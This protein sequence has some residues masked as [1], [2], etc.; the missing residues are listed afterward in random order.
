MLS[1][2]IV[3]P[4]MF[5]SEYAIA[6]KKTD[7]FSVPFRSLM[8]YSVFNVD[9]FIQNPS[10]TGTF[11][12]MGSPG[13]AFGSSGGF[14]TSESS[15]ASG[16]PKIE[17][18]YCMRPN[19]AMA[20]YGYSSKMSVLVNSGIKAESLKEGARKL[21]QELS[22]DWRS[23]KTAAD[24]KFI[25]NASR[26][27]LSKSLQETEK[28]NSLGKALVKNGV[29]LNEFEPYI[30]NTLE[31][32][33]RYPSILA[34]FLEGADEEFLKVVLEEIDLL[35]CTKSSP[36]TSVK[37]SRNTK[38]QFDYDYDFAELGTGGIGM[39]MSDAPTTLED[40][41]DTVPLKQ[42]VRDREIQSAEDSWS[43]EENS[44]SGQALKKT[45]D[46]VKKS[47]PSVGDTAINSAFSKECAFKD[48][49]RVKETLCQSMNKPVDVII[50]RPFPV[51]ANAGK[52]CTNFHLRYATDKNYNLKA[53][54]ADNIGRRTFTIKKIDETGQQSTEV[55]ST[56]I[57]L[58][59]LRDYF[60]TIKNSCGNS[61][62]K[63]AVAPK[64]KSK[65]AVR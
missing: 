59:E 5:F 52:S 7:T 42:Y 43:L 46:A 28:V 53:V 40:M 6:T 45:I 8:P 10:S 21:A 30:R 39:G 56:K 62:A 57:E 47:D 13:G 48:I 12:F 2:L 50:D 55:K 15:S 54:N 9:L 25:L 44:P 18:P 37:Y 32:G 11:Q 64:V 27:F 58:S 29:T 49:P 61:F 17:T 60:K 1:R 33:K 4:F 38:G 26:G 19:T 23:G 24:K 35:D 20:C 3:I 14:G 16:E 31:G 34:G 51:D 22:D 36:I 41:C 63:K 65:K